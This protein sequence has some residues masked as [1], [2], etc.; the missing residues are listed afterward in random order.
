MNT[1]VHYQW[2]FNIESGINLLPCPDTALERFNDNRT[3]MHCWC[4]TRMITWLGTFWTAVRHNFGPGFDNFWARGHPLKYACCRKTSLILLVYFN[5]NI[6]FI[7][8]IQ[9]SDK[10]RRRLE[11]YNKSNVDWKSVLLMNF[12]CTNYI[13]WT[14]SHYHVDKHCN[15]LT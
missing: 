1:T 10:F 11:K 2:F 12:K 14:K 9:I 4:G 3:I 5:Q 7:H 8:I 15:Y 13:L 6:N